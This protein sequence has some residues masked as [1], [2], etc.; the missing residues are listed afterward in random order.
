MCPKCGGQL[1]PDVVWFGEAVEMH[2]EM[3]ESLLADVRQ[4]DGVFLCVGTSAQVYPAASLIPLFAPARRKYIV[5]RRPVRVAD[6]TL[7]E[8][9]AGE[10]L[11]KLVEQLLRDE[12]D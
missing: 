10:M 12:A 2:Y 3:L 4:N 6:Y 9:P 1:R 5:D 8:G 7:I 11:P